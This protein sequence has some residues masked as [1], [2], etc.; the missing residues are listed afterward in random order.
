MKKGYFLVFL[1]A[2]ISGLSV[3]INKYGVSINNPNIFTFLKNLIVAILLSGVLIIFRDFRELKKLNK[4]QWFL[5]LSIGLIGGSIPFLLFFKGLSLI[6]AAQGSFWHKTMFL[7]VAIISAVFLKEKISRKFLFGGLLILFGN[8]FLLKTIPSPFYKGDVLVILATI[9]WAFENV[10]SKYTLK[11]LS[12]QI[13]AWARM[14]FGSISILLFLLGT[15]QLKVVADLNLRQISWIL[16]TAILLFGYVETWYHGLKFVPVSQATVI[17]ALG[18]PI[19]TFLS[20]I[21]GGKIS[22]QETISGI[23]IVFGII[24][25]LGFKEFWKLI[26]ETKKSYAQ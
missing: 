25:I 22:F 1:T 8:L 9:F 26:K 15:N 13:V 2:I 20:F 14:F 23:L 7:Y 3:F 5:L 21:S 11:N 24:S 10:I 12:P 16:V 18:S 17:L 19:T 6:T 4:K